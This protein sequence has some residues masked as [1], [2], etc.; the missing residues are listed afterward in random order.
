[1]TIQQEAN[2][3]DNPLGLPLIRRWGFIGCQTAYKEDEEDY[4]R[5]M[6]IGWQKREY[7]LEP[8]SV[9][10]EAYAN[11]YPKQHCASMY[12]LVRLGVMCASVYSHIHK[13]I[14]AVLNAGK[15]IESSESTSRYSREGF[16]RTWIVLTDGSP[17]ISGDLKTAMTRKI[18]SRLLSRSLTVTLDDAI[19]LYPQAWERVVD[20]LG[21]ER[22]SSEWIIG[23][24][25][26]EQL[27]KYLELWQK[28]AVSAI[29]NEIL[30]VSSDCEKDLAEEIIEYA[31]TLQF[32][33]ERIAAS[34]IENCKD[35]TRL[36]RIRIVSRFASS[37]KNR[38]R[39]IY[40]KDASSDF[41]SAEWVD[42][43]KEDM[44]ARI[45]AYQLRAQGTV[46]HIDHIVPLAALPRH[47]VIDHTSLAWHPS[48]LA[49]IS[50]S[51]NVRKGSAF[52]GERF[53]HR[54]VDESSEKD[55]VAA[56]KENYQA[57]Y[58]RL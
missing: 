38:I 2:E 8:S 15:I 29:S 57:S 17:T 20:Y 39:K 48:N 12:I 25:S 28:D 35:T 18:R 55:A 3:K 33:K 16:N 30:S 53:I 49:I 10:L 4:G 46:F 58:V 9:S 5:Y 14:G 31:Y 26:V 21:S 41:N 19:S 42:L 1:M 23:C 43:Y 24:T 52:Q 47:Y 6:E 51:D 32:L 40:G 27:T 36:G 44:L 13:R 11:G 45:L 54:I 34:K 22:S 50:A 37:S 7:S 56:L